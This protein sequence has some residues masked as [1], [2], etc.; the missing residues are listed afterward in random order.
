M[1]TE[2]RA[3]L[4]CYRPG[5]PRVIEQLEKLKE[6]EHRQSR[7]NCIDFLVIDGLRERGLWPPVSSPSPDHPAA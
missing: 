1:A 2:S 6:Q 4:I 7:N 5:D 3:G